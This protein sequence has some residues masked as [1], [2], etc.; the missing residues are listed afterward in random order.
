[1]TFYLRIQNIQEIFII[2][3]N[4]IADWWQ[5]CIVARGHS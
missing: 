3:A 5:S 1:M 4:L 2:W